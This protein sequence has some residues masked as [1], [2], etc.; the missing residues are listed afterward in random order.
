MECGKLTAKLRDAVQVCFIEEGKE[1]KRY[2][3]IEIPDEIK[4]LTY[5]DFVFSVPETGAI[6]FK[7]IFEPGTLPEIWPDARTRNHRSPKP[8][9]T[10]T[11]VVGPESVETGESALQA[12]DAVE[13][14]KMPAQP[15]HG[16]AIEANLEYHVVG[17]RR[18]ELVHAISEHLNIKAQ[19]LGMPQRKF[20][21]GEYTVSP[22]GLVT[23]PENPELIAALEEKGFKAE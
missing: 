4:K 6:T 12:T 13:S 3:N 15:A 11:A 8:A 23:G 10:T 19:Y 1:I 18:K 7:I 5:K 20:Q 9:A 17:E 16:E 14:P 21:I 22:S 2:K